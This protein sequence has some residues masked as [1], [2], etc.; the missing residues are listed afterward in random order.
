MEMNKK[1]QG[2]K[3]TAKKIIFIVS[4]RILQKT[5]KF[6]KMIIIKRLYFEL[7]IGPTS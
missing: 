6:E 5:A 3:L 4:D 1:K 7:F 2:L